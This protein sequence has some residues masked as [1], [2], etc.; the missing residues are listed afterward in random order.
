MRLTLARDPMTALSRMQNNLFDEDFFNFNW[1]DTRIDM[2]EEEDNKVVVKLMA[3]GFNQDNIDISVEGNN[4]TITGKSELKEE[5]GDNK[6]K[7]YRKEIRTQSFTRTISL[8][9]K[10]KAEDAVA[11]F[12]E[13]ILILTMPK[14]EEAMP[15][16]ISISAK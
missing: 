14:A 12:K 2:Y 5:E 8:P 1:D 11:E 3:P 13:G 10:V 6:R 9:S 16:K 15:K 7:Y 4:L